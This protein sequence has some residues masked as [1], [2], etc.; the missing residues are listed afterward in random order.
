MTTE[1]SSQGQHAPQGRWSRDGRSSPSIVPSSLAEQIKNQ[2]F[3][4]RGLFDHWYI[5]GKKHEV[6]DARSPRRQAQAP[7][8][9]QRSAKSKDT[10]ES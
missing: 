2:R 6:G 7:E 10:A 8:R 4:V 9:T 5:A 3:T 1:R